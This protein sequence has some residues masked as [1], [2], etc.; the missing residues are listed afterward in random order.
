MLLAVG[1]LIVL[2]AVTRLIVRRSWEE[3]V[4]N[5]CYGAPQIAQSLPLQL[6]NSE[7]KLARIGVKGFREYPE[8]DALVVGEGSV[9]LYW[10][11]PLL[12]WTPEILRSRSE[13][14]S[15]NFRFAADGTVI[16]NCSHGSD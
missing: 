8:P 7:W 16:A 5:F 6:S 3:R 13:G 10:E 12:S 11:P 9:S 1:A 15:L 2:L 4:R 14:Y